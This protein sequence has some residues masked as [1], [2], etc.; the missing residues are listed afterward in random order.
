LFGFGFRERGVE[1]GGDLEQIKV[2]ESPSSTS[3]Y[4]NDKHNVKG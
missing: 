1:S 3:P 4:T 2:K